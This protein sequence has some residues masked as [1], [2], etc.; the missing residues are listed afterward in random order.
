MMPFQYLR[1]FFFFESK[2]RRFSVGIIF[3]DWKQVKENNHLE[4]DS[5][6]DEDISQK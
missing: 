6:S 4:S 5:C 1:D 2:K 3:C